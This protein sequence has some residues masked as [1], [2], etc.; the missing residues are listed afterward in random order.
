M[1]GLLGPVLF[2]HFEKIN[3]L[4]FMA[5]SHL[6]FFFRHT[7]THS[8]SLSLFYKSALHRFFSLLLSK[9]IKKSSWIC[10]FTW[11]KPCYCWHIFCQFCLFLFCLLL[12]FFGT[13][14]IHFRDLMDLFI[15]IFL[16]LFIFSDKM[17]IKLDSIIHVHAS[18]CISIHKDRHRCEMWASLRSANL[19]TL[20][21][22]CGVGCGPAC[23]VPICPLKVW[24]GVGCGPA[25]RVP[26]CPLKVW[27]GVGCRPACGVPTCPLWKSGVGRR[28]ACWVLTWPLWKSG[29]VWDVDQ[30]A[31]CQPAHFENFVWCGTW[32]SL[33]TEH[34][35]STPS[36]ASLSTDH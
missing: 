20:K 10:C 16:N 22:W 31:K 24:F 11:C 32:A 29:V 8:L 28:P 27:F 34:R 15:S 23:G 18:P 30:L 25:C 1:F 12:P 13:I 2:P 5:T 33:P 4:H 7:H 36:L 26:T 19:T 9:A 6:V 21:V 3:Y 17:F 14:L 35:I